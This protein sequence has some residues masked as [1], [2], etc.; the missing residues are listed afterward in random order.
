MQIPPYSA[1]KW[2]LIASVAL[3]GLILL[4]PLHRELEKHFVSTAPD[5]L[6]VI[7]K[8]RPSTSPGPIATPVPSKAD[9]AQKPLN[10]PTANQSTTVPSI[11][12]NAVPSQHSLSE[13]D[14]KHYSHPLYPRIAMLQG[15]EGEVELGLWTLDGH[16]VGKVQVL[17]SSGYP[18]LDQAALSAARKWIFSQRIDPATKLT[19]KIIFKIEN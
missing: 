4:F 13:S 9:L 15:L 17:V 11:Q 18:I 10:K 6:S 12:N 5:G 1:P 7:L 3:H 2:L 16:R 8:S 19:K 14:F